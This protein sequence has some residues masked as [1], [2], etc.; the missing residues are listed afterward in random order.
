MKERPILFSTS[1][2]QAILEGHK[3]QTRRIIRVPPLDFLPSYKFGVG[4]GL[5]NTWTWWYTPDPAESAKPFRCKYGI[6]GD[7]L[8]VRESWRIVGWGE[9]DWK[10]EYKDGTSKWFDC[11]EEVTEV[12]E[13]EH[14]I[15]CSD[16]C[17]KAGLLIG[18][19]DT[20]ILKDGIVPTRWRPSIHMPRWASRIQLEIVSVR[21]DRLQEISRDD[22]FCE[23]ISPINPYKTDPDLPPGLPAVF[24]DY[25]D[26]RNWFMAD[27]VRSFQSLW[28]SINAGRGFGWDTN[29]WVW[30]IEF[31]RIK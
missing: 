4:V 23:G 8:Y 3:T 16:D 21:A 9:G 30:V 5:N 1:M 31:R 27:P 6:P 26:K 18:P 2:V 22:A 28:D 25:Q 24:P 29:P 10:I 13:S 7:Q 19:D 14:C 17:D 20:Y 15:Q 12:W 11:P